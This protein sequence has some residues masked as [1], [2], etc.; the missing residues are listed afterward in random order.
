[1]VNLALPLLSN[2]FLAWVL[3]LGP[4]PTHAAP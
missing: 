2:T 4:L 1:M 3:G